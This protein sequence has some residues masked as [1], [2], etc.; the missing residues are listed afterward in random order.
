MLIRILFLISYVFL[1]DSSC[2]ATQDFA[3]EA[4][5]GFRRILKSG[6]V[7]TKKTAEKA[8]NYLPD[9]RTYNSALNAA[10]WAGVFSGS[11]LH[12]ID[13]NARDTNPVSNPAQIFLMVMPAM[14]ILDQLV[15][16]GGNYLDKKFPK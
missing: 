11:I 2:F 16:Y 1:S 4:S 14:A 7:A 13:W 10:Y 9:R 6:V 8:K 5:G 15:H 12:V 3:Q